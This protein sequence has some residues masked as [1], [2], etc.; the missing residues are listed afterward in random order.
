M[1]WELHV[2]QEELYGID[3]KE[4]VHHMYICRNQCVAEVM[5][6]KLEADGYSV[7]IREFDPSP[8]DMLNM[9]EKLCKLKQR[10]L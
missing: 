9:N 1:S 7:T 4:V 10:R 8:V 6:G 3:S 5:K 2:L